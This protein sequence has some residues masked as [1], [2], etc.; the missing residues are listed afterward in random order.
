MLRPYR[1]HEK[2]SPHRSATYRRCTCPV[3]VDGTLERR[4]VRKSLD[5]R[6]WKLPE[7]Q[8]LAMGMEPAPAISVEDACAAYLKE[9]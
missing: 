6:N 5:T 1:R 7:E 4:R 2:S 9:R 3:W 8:V